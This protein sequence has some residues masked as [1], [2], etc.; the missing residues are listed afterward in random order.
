MICINCFHNKTK[1]TNSRPH[2]LNPAVWRRRQCPKC[3]TIFTTYERPAL[4]DKLILGHDR[5]STPFSIGKLTVSIAK[6][7]L[8]DKEAADQHSYFLAQTIET[9]LLLMAKELSVDDIASVAH[10]TLK[11]F[12]PVSAIQYAAQHDLVTQTRRPGR[13]SISYEV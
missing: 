12:D 4:E 1:V 8:H 13:P 2:K 3:Q 9:K 5:K 7:F 6:S 11:E 10:Q